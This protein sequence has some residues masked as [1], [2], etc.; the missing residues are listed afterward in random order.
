MTNS[1]KR[2][3]IIL[4]PIVIGAALALCFVL[5]FSQRP[6]TISRQ[7]NVM[8]LHNGDS[9]QDAL[10]AARPGDTLLLD[11]GATFL[12]PFTLPAKP[13]SAGPDGGYITIRSSADDASLAPNV[14]VTPAS[15][16]LMP[17][18]ISPGK[19]ATAIQTAPGAHH[20]RFIGIEFT[21]QTDSALVYEL[22]SFGDGSNAQNTLDRVPHHLVLD[23]CYIHALGGQ[24]LKRGVGLNSSETT[25][26]NSWVSGFKSTDQDTQA[27]MGFNG[28]GP[29]HIV[30]NYLESSGEN[31]MFGGAD[32]SIQNLVPSDIEIKR[33]YFNKPLSWKIDDPAY[34]GTHWVVKNLLEL[35]NAQRV[36]IEGNLFEHCWRDA[37]GGTAVVLTPR[38]QGGNAPWST[39]N[40][41]SI[42]SNIIRHTNN[43]IGMLSADDERKSEFEH[44]IDI[45]NNLAYDIDKTKWGVKQN[46]GTF[47]SF[48]GPGESKV[49]ISHNT[50]VH[51]GNGILMEDNTRISN[52][53]IIDNI[54]H[55]HILGG[56][57][58]G[59]RALDVRVRGWKVKRNAIVI[60]QE[61]SSWIPQYPPDNYYP[62]SYDAIGFADRSKSNF[63][64]GTNSGVRGKSTDA[65]DIGVDFGVLASSGAEQAGAGV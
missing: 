53:S 4:L 23:R 1:Q 7:G 63:R 39:V 65:R 38:N 20:Y 41:V 5:A 6:R 21:A 10:D 48:N 8:R 25:V 12:G 2:S 45:T 58:G 18:I 51:T 11:A 19:G 50:A 17:R 34:A 22:V 9:L 36:A 26:V 33:N 42:T 28:P 56:D 43:A 37:Q 30:N 40:T 35:K 57:T 16:S 52:L 47:I 61:A 14:R 46:G 31:V 55:F 29:F 60:D 49:T 3:L 27:L 44:D 15:T 54:M 13:V 32:P 24:S 59:S 64:P 62:A